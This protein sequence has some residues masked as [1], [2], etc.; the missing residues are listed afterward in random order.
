MSTV[1]W[2]EKHGFEGC[3]CMNCEDIKDCN[4]AAECVKH[5]AWIEGRKR[6]MA[7]EIRRLELISRSYIRTH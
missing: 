2:S 6:M 4:P 5:L 3:P 1:T 7:D